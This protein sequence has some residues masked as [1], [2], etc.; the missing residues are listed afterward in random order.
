MSLL[1]KPCNKGGSRD[2]RTKRFFSVISLLCFAGIPTDKRG[3]NLT[4][5]DE[6]GHWGGKREDDINLDL[7]DTL[8]IYGEKREVKEILNNHIENIMKPGVSLASLRPQGRSYTFT[9]SMQCSGGSDTTHQPDQ[10]SPLL[11]ALPVHP[12][13]PESHLR[14][15]LLSASQEKVLF[16]IKYSFT[17]LSSFKLKIYVRFSASS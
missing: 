3:G 10:W 12:G 5:T 4:G 2:Q 7:D 17:K 14:P 11:N 15:R 6:M 1:L 8:G 13:L 9:Y 16:P